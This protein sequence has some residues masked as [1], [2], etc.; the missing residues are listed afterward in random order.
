MNLNVQ[1]QKAADLSTPT[2]NLN[3]SKA[4]ALAFG[5][6]ANNGNM[7][8]SDRRTLAASTNETLDLVG[9]LAAPLSPVVSF[10]KIKMLLIKNTSDA[11]G[12]PTIAAI[13]IEPGATYPPDNCPTIPKLPAGGVVLIAC[14][15]ADGF[16][17]SLAGGTKD[18]LKISNLDG[19]YGC[20][21]DIII[22]GESA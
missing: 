15:D 10:S 4:I 9:V 18:L 5:T 19:S 1:A 22:V 8:W 11:L 17:G 13:K 16:L 20:Q 21:Y 6:G 2:E 14:G 7:E 12:T 3:A